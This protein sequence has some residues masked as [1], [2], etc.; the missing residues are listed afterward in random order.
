MGLIS[1]Y[2]KVLWAPFFFHLFFFTTLFFCSWFLVTRFYRHWTFHW[3]VPVGLG[4]LFS[5]GVFG[6]TMIT[7][8]QN[9]LA[10]DA[11]PKQADQASQAPG[12]A[13]QPAAPS[14]EDQAR[15]Q[16]KQEFLKAIDALVQNPTLV[17]PDTKNQLF[18][19]YSPILGADDKARKS[20]IGSLV[21]AYECQAHFLS[22]FQKSIEKKKVYKSSNREACQKLDGAFF[23]REL[24]ITPEMAKSNDD[25]IDKAVKTQRVPAADGKEQIVTVESIQASFEAQSKAVQ[26]VKSILLQ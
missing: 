16:A 5:F 11:Q 2:M 13:Q 8:Y 26:I 22:D 1:E 4:F 14:P 23:G 10:Y 3:Q 12:Q 20:T 19:K 6:N 9:K 24:L 15:I 7:A 25:V 18:Q 17:T 21:A